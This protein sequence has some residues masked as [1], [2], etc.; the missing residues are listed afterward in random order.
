MTPQCQ[1]LAPPY[2]ALRRV[3]LVSP[4][5]VGQKYKRLACPF[6]EWHINFDGANAPN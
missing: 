2:V 5:Y 3:Y 1:I 6:F 4:S